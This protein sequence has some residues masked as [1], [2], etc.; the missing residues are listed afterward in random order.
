MCKFV[1]VCGGVGRG[2]KEEIN[3]VSGLASYEVQHE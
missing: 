2:A 3:K 1:L